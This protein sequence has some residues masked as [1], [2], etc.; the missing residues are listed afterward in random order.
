VTTP[1]G[2]FRLVIFENE[3]DGS[4]HPV[5]VMGELEEGDVPPARIHSQCLTGDAF[6]SLRCDCGDQLAASMTHMRETGKG[7]LVYLRQEGR[8]IGLTNKV[9]AYGLQDQGKD[10]VDANLALGFQADE[11]SYVL[12][13]QIFKNLGLS[14]VKLI[15]NNERKIRETEEW[16]VRVAERI[17]LDVALR[18]ENEAYLK[19]KRDRLGHLLSFES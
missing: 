16:G 5:F 15:T 14:S 4:T 18:P 6:H 11:R 9:R 3:L 17:A 1:F 2:D 12:A 13:A 10:T 7:V 8:G 19:T